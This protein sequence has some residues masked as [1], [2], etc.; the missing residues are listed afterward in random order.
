MH[1]IARD[2]LGVPVSLQPADA[3]H[4]SRFDQI[5]TRYG[6]FV[7]PMISLFLVLAAWFLGEHSSAGTRA[8]LGGIAIAGYP[9]IRNAV[10]STISKRKLNA[11]VLVSIALIAS[12]WVGE[13]MAGALVA[14]MMLTGE[15]L[16]DLTIAKTGQAIRSL[17]SLEPL[18]ARV[19][20]DNQA[21]ERPIGEVVVGDLVVV[22][23]GER[24]PVDG[25][26]SEGRGEVDQAAI[27]GESIAVTKEPGC[28]V[29]GG[30]F[31]QL[32]VLQVTVSRTGQ[33]TTLSKIIEL[34]QKAQA[35]KPPIERIADRFSSWFTPVILSLAALVW[36]STGEVL[37]GVT[38]L[39][40]ACPCALVIATPTAV[41]AGI[42]NAA[43]KGILIKGG[44]VLETI[45]KLNVFAFDKTGTLTFGEPQVYQVQG[46]GGFQQ[47][48]VL[49]LAASAEQNTG[50]PLAEAVLKHTRAKALEYRAADET[51]VIAGRGVQAVIR[52]SGKPEQ[53]ILVGN[54]SFFR[55]QGLEP[56]SEAASLLERAATEGVTGILVGRDDQIV[57]GITFTDTLRPEVHDSVAALRA[58]AIE[59][60]VM[61]TGDTEAVARTILED[62]GL[63]AIAADLLPE[64]KLDYV[65][66]LQAEGKT[67]AMVGDGIND[68]PALV[69][70]DVGIAMGVAGTDAAIEAAD[71]ALTT[72]RLDRVAEAIALSR[73]TITVIKQ[74]LAIS[75]GINGVALLLAS[76]GGI[77]PVAGAFIHNI[78]SIIVVGNSSRLLGYSYQRKKQ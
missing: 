6:D 4:Q 40:V 57:G 42:G 43:R 45:S 78:G 32:G 26:V 75:I 77:G 5:L 73:K 33:D 21:I 9:I 11:E 7:T 71:V 41:V 29:Y 74:S 65:K 52:E 12:V 70:A 51:R 28:Q 63:D 72:D 60:V 19:I 22:Q 69:E 31:N 62:G 18:T 76:T 3:G 54:P 8:A 48:E 53:V 37:R 50:H 58:L 15:L 36:G 46:F 34:V 49:R 13:Y 2:E 61:L 68:A 59:R 14:V 44:A 39:V 38:V 1:D 67:V 16:E 27:T 25:V 56:G 17:M 10:T 30:T 23:P 55:E 66:R 24:I 20:R 47:E 64:Q 35:E